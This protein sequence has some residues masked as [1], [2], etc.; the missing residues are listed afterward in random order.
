MRG[1]WHYVKRDGQEKGIFS[2]VRGGYFVLRNL[3]ADKV[4]GELKLTMR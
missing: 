1:I 2:G 4:Y 3:S